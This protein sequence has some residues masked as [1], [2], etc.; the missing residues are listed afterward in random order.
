MF[1]E[2]GGDEYEVADGYVISKC[3]EDFPMLHFLF[4]DKWLTVE[5][6]SYVVDISD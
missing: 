6:E 5:P 3:Y 1:A 2:M 4:N